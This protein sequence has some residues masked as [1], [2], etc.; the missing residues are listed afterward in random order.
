MILQNTAA[1]T[2]FMWLEALYHQWV[3]HYCAS[4]QIC[5]EYIASVKCCNQQTQ[6]VTCLCVMVLYFNV[7]LSY[8]VEKFC[9]PCP[10]FE[11]TQKGKQFKELKGSFQ[12]N[13]AVTVTIGVVLCC[14]AC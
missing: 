12:E 6:N 9:P 11:A 8:R 4:C 14:G 13:E 3:H 7:Y 1:L 10:D 5:P 2:A